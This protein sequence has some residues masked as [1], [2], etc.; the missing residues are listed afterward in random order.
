MTAPAAFQATIHAF[1]TVPSRGVVSITIE[2]PIERHAEIARIAVH[3]AWVAVA[4][5]QNSE[6]EVMPNPTTKHDTVSGHDN[7]Q[8]QPDSPRQAGAKRDWRDIPP[9]QQAG[10]RCDEAIFAAFLKEQRSD[11]WHETREAADCV[12]LICGIA[13]RSE[14]GVNHK[15]RVIW[16][17]LD[18]Q[19]QAWLAKESVQ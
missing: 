2:A 8:P 17:N 5:L 11:D 19:Y 9:A 18:A 6:T 10:I 14:L 7:A 16:N 15:A 12:R 4:R 1:R 3:G 13:S